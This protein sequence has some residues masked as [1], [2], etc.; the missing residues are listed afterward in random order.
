MRTRSYLFVRPDGTSTDYPNRNTLLGGYPGVD[1]IKTGF[2]SAA[3]EC[4]V[5]HL[6]SAANGD[7]FS[8]VVSASAT[9]A[10]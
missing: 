10:Q 4:L 3:G 7:D 2:T 5:T 1:G 6:H 8:A 9:V